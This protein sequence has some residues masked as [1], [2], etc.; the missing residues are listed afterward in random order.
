MNPEGPNLPGIPLDG[1]RIVSMRPPAE[2][3]EASNGYADVTTEFVRAV[4]ARG[5]RL[6]TS[7]EGVPITFY[8]C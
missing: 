2:G 3:R 4:E 6:A 7:L 5:M 8:H 1:L